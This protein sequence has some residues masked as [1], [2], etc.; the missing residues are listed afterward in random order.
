MIY[1][2]LTWLILTMLLFIL[3]RSPEVQHYLHISNVQVSPTIALNLIF[4]ALAQSGLFLLAVF[5]LGNWS[6]FYL[7]VLVT[8]LVFSSICELVK[9]LKYVVR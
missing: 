8:F 2:G 6:E 4:A 1:L 9:F 5:G 7:L 3:E